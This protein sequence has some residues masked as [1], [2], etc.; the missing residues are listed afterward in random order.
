MLVVK[1]PPVSAGDVKRHGFNPW[2]RKILWKR[3]W[4]PTPVFLPGKSHGQRTLVGHSP[5]GY[6]ES[7]LTYLLNLL[8]QHIIKFKLFLPLFLPQ[9]ELKIWTCHQQMERDFMFP[10]WKKQYCEKWLYYQMQA[11]DLMRSLSNYQWYFLKNLNKKLHNSYGN[12]QDTKL[13]KQSWERRMELEESTFLTS[14]YTTKLQSSRECG[15][16]TKAEI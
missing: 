13:P 16:G 11:T 5:W 10:G 15:T 2:V 6:N 3:K 9:T 8:L 7:D 12:T 4:Q 1:N 14:D